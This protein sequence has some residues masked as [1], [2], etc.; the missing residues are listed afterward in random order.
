MEESAKREVQEE[1]GL[2]VIETKYQTN[3]YN[4]KRDLLMFG[5]ICKVQNDDFN[6]SKEVDNAKWFS[7]EEAISAVANKVIQAMIKEYFKL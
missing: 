1:T 5:V 6:I 2:T 4:E 3:Y 7:P